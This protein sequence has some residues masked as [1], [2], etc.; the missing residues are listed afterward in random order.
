MRI[1]PI[2][3][4]GPRRRAAAQRGFS[5][6]ELSIALVVIGLIIGAVAVGRDLQRNASYQRISS[7]FVQGWLMAYDAYVA[8][9][10]IVPGDS[11]TAPTGL[12]NG[13]TNELCGNDLLNV[14]LAAGIRLPQGRAEGQ[15][16][17]YA[18]LDSNGNPQEVEVCLQNVAWA[19]PGTAVGTYVS[20]PRN[21]MVLKRLT[22][23]LASCWTRRSTAAP[24]RASAACGR[25]PRPP[26][27]P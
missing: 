14:F 23:A 8:G 19:E 13:N 6:L 10:G 24:M 5:M 27:W 22:P 18:Y 20:R 12:V 11:A 15:A 1:L 26:W 2:H 17:R 3:R 4:P 21:V 7:S 25:T 16:S 9:T